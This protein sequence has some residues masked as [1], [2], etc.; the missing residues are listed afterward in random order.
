MTYHVAAAA[1][2]CAEI[3][4]QGEVNGAAGTCMPHLLVR[5]WVVDEIQG[6]SRRME[7]TDFPVTD[8]AHEQTKKNLFWLDHLAELV[9]PAKCPKGGSPIEADAALAVLE[10]L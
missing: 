6:V 1:G 4:V 10:T 3:L 5:G 7:T 9:L 2:E 8:L